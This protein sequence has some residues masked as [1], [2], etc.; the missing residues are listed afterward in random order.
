MKE[1]LPVIVRTVFGLGFTI[2]GLN[3]FFHFLPLP[4]PEGEAAKFIDAL[5]GSGYFYQ[6]LKGTELVCGLLLLSGYF[7]PLALVVLAPV[8]L[9]IVLFHLFLD[10]AGLP[11]G[12]ILTAIEVYLAWAYGGSFKGVLTVKATT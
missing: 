7:V 1:K 6:F 8:L 3:G 2:F 11:T 5:V 9:N 12:I 4:P 10:P